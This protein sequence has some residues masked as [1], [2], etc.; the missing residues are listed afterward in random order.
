MKSLS[1]RQ[2]LQVGREQWIVHHN[3]LI[4]F[5]IRLWGPLGIHT[6]IRN[7]RVINA[8]SRL[9]LPNKARILD[10]GCGH[11]YTTFW[12]ARHHP[13]Y[14]IWA[15]DADPRFIS[16]GEKIALRLGLSNVKFILADIC[17]LK[18]EEIAIFDLI[19]SIDLLEHIEDDIGLLC[20]F[21]RALRSQGYL[22]LHL[23]R[24][25][26]EHRR[27]FPVFKHHTTPDHVRDE[28]TADEICE[29]LT[30]AKFWVESLYYG[31]SGWGELAF[32]LNNLFWKYKWLRILTALLTH[33][34]CIWLGYMD[35]RHEYKD[36][37][38]L[39]VIARPM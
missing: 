30:Q 28:Y 34:L 33:P 7:T 13:Q 18:L 4:Q 23:P 15:V 36:G 9:E 37:N 27:F 35:T 1:Y 29:R 16:E 12:L 38:S 5:Y 25:H 22:V 19:F 21:R 20:A 6:R 3:P 31:F 10:A 17:K 11:G 14:H 26:Q 32:E 8:I 24:R 2:F 39:L